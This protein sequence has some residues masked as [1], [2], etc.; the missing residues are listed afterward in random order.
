MNPADRSSLRKE[1]VRRT[2]N[3]CIRLATLGLILA[4]PGAQAGG[5]L[6]TEPLVVPR[7]LPTAATTTGA[8]SV[9]RIEAVAQ[10]LH[11]RGFEEL[12]VV[13]WAMLD[14]GR[15]E[16]AAS[17]VERAAELA[18]STPSLQFEAARE[19]RSFAH[20]VR[21]LLAVPRSLPGLIWL[22]SVGGAVVGCGL[23]IAAALLM[24]LAFARTATLNGHLL[25]HLITTQ[26]PP[27]WPGV[28]VILL[29]LALLPLAGAGPALVLAAAGMIAAPRLGR[30]ERLAPAVL[31]VVAGLVLGPALD[32]WSRIGALAGQ[33]PAL[34]SAW[35]LENAQPLAGDRERLASVA[36]ARRDDLLLRVVLAKTW[37][38][39]GDLERADALLRE[40]PSVAEPALLARAE[41]LRGTVAVA[42]GDLEAGIAAFEVAR[43]AEE[44]AAVLYNL[45]QAHGRAV[46]LMERSSLFEAARALDPDLVTKYTAFAGSNVHRYLIQDPVP[47]S[48][49]V[50]RAFQASAESRAIVRTVR[51][52]AFG[53]RTPGWV[54]LL[55]PAAG[56]TGLLFRR[57][58]IWRCGRCSRAV[59]GHC[60]SSEGATETTCGRCARLFSRDGRSDPRLR[61]QVLD[62]EKRQQRLTAAALAGVALAA[63]GVSRILEGRMKG[64]AIALVMLTLGWTFAL[65]PQV[66]VAPFELG[67]LGDWLWLV[68]AAMLIPVAY[69]VGL[70]DARGYLLR[71]R[72]RP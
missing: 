59:C 21:A 19:L 8:S 10:A 43:A 14:V 68:P 3:I 50:Q 65:S 31:L 40:L 39:S 9:D 22:L 6:R 56:M 67:E 15:R 44:S 4:A 32:A 16:Q 23:L 55:L 2:T 17:V 35:R 25:G 7:G 45:A 42:R 30:G 57:G 51:A 46:R 29:A 37:L 18:V 62:L 60:D 34:V 52:W 1:G 47:L 41:T 64:G 20:L 66:L 5:E 61:R 72:A 58:T 26:D 27:S 63:P 28:L 48:I 36:E 12:P 69:L 54:W 33:D 71:M 70:L 53:P 49:Y 11:D 13:A 24:A 38:R